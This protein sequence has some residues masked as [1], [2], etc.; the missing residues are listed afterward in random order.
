M[1]DIVQDEISVAGEK[2][3]VAQAVLMIN[4][5]YETLRKTCGQTSVQVK[6]S[7]HRYIIGPKGSHIT[8]IMQKTGVAIAIPPQDDPS[9]MVILRGPQSNLQLASQLMQ[10]KVFA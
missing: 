6:K 9:D 10:E 2:P 8:E 3:A 1:N 4:Q 7:Q 5:I